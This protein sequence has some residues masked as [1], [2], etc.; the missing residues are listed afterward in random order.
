[1][2]KKPCGELP[3]LLPCA[4]KPCLCTGGGF[5]ERGWGGSCNAG[6]TFG[7]VLRP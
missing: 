3:V 1:M 5:D 2:G 7:A 6:I 4:G